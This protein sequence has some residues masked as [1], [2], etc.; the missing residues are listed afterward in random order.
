MIKI[1][2]KQQEKLAFKLNYLK[3]IKNIENKI[4][5]RTRTRRY[6]TQTKDRIIYKN[7]RK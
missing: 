6:M 7:M 4:K 5:T 1:N 3:N 2:T